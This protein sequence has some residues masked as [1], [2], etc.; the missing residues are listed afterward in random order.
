MRPEDSDDPQARAA[1]RRDN[2]RALAVALAAV[3]VVGVAGAALLSQ[4]AGP[5]VAAPAPTPHTSLAPGRQLPTAPFHGDGD[6]DTG[7]DTPLTT[8]PPTPSR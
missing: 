1:D 7:T 5:H 6:A 4:Q 8:T 3:L 2:R